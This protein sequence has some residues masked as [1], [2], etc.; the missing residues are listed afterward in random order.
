[1]SRISRNRMHPGMRNTV[2]PTK[3]SAV[4]R[5]CSA[6]VSSLSVGERAE[7]EAHLEA[8]K[9]EVRR[10]RLFSQRHKRLI[11]VRRHTVKLVT[12]D[13]SNT[14]LIYDGPPNGKAEVNLRE[15][16]Q[17]QIAKE[18]GR[19]WN[20]LSRPEQ[21]RRIRFGSEARCRS[22]LDIRD[23]HKINSGI[24]NAKVREATKSWKLN[25]RQNGQ[26]QSLI[27]FTPARAM[28]ASNKR[29]RRK[30]GL[31]LARKLSEIFRKG[32]RHFYFITI[33]NQQWHTRHDRTKIRIGDIRQSIHS[34]ME[35][36]GFN[37][38]GYVEFDI[39]NNA[40]LP[41]EGL[42]VMPHV[43][44]IAWRKRALKPKKLA[45]KWDLRGSFERFC[46]LRTVDIKRVKA[47]DDLMHLSYYISKP[48]SVVK[49]MKFEPE[50]GILQQVF[51][52]ENA[53]RPGLILR[54]SEILSH[55]TL[56][57]IFLIG[58]VEGTR[59]GDE[60]IKSINQWHSKWSNSGFFIPDIEAFW[61]EIRPKRSRRFYSSVRIIYQGKG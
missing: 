35:G 40:Q 27:G 24:V 2:M 13:G 17:R 3:V 32:D 30:A 55:L 26:L 51:T 34:F 58:G 43:H 60:V 44:L 50:S 59:L 10:R 7:V 22:R 57:D 36:K 9:E 19:D 28:Y 39:F 20:R 29:I 48:N 45:K 5:T 53:A 56:A 41:G 1:M 18:K 4:S 11:S 42:L 12:P 31:V 38:C 16:Q 47:A 37:W 54:L 33:T 8:K 23:L 25:P 6:N 49:S 61:S 46:G 14:R 21:N 15:A 52:V